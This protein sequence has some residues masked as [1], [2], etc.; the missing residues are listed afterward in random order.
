[1][2]CGR[3]WGQ[4][5]CR[6]S[7][8]APAGGVSGPGGG[9]SPRGCARLRPCA[10]AVPAAWSDHGRHHRSLCR[11]GSAGP[12]GAVGRQTGLRT[13]TPG[14][15]TPAGGHSGRGGVTTL[16]HGAPPGWASVMG[17]SR[18]RVPG[19]GA[20]TREG[21]PGSHL[22]WPRPALGRRC[23]AA[24]PGGTSAAWCGSAPS[25]GQSM[26]RSPLPQAPRGTPY[27]AEPQGAGR[28][29]PVPPK[30]HSLPLQLVQRLPLSLPVRAQALHDAGL[31]QGHTPGG[32]WRVRGAP[33]TQE[34]PPGPQSH[35]EGCR[36]EA[37][38]SHMTC[39]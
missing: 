34:D 16:L 12:P 29:V 23:G 30:T 21:P 1:M 8:T 5:T 28:G 9:T 25:C 15:P 3:A 26:L 27:T 18:T 20:G 22:I 14:A 32:Q 38:R 35:L 39:K 31:E 10:R 6:V 17:H 4:G 11:D 36:A 7:P 37:W 33:S 13:A 19:D 24:A 2:P